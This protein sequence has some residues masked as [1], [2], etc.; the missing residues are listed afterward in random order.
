[1]QFLDFDH[2]RNALLITLCSSLNRERN[3]A[4]NQQWVPMK[5][6]DLKN[7]M[8]AFHPDALLNSSANRATLMSK[9]YID[10]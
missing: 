8:H 10:F 1:M 7:C 3:D 2:C 4:Y 5:D 6:I 9:L